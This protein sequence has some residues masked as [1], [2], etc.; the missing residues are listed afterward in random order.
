MKV[1]T[2]PD[3]SYFMICQRHS[4]LPS[5][6]NVVER[7]IFEFFRCYSLALRASNLSEVR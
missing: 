4:Y 7:E 2:L 1:L 5:G 6:I 3:L